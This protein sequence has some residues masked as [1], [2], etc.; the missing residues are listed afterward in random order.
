MDSYELTR[1]GE[2]R[3]VIEVA[4]RGERLLNHPMYNKGSAF[5]R[6]ERQTFGLEGLL[7]DVV[8]PMERQAQRIVGH[9]ARKAD[10]LEKYIGLS[11]LQDRNEHLFYRVLL[12]NLEEYL[13]IVYTPTVGKASQRYSHIFRR[14]R[15]IFIT[16]RHRGRIAEVLRNAPFADVRLIVATDNSA[17]LGL[18]DQGAGGM[19]IPIGKLAIYCAAAGIH[20]TQTLPVSLDVGTDRDELLADDLY[21]G[22]REKR[23]RGE[24][25]ATLV[26]EFVDAV[27]EVFPRALLQWEDFSKRN[28]FEVLERHRRRIPSFND[29]I[30]GTGATALAGV[31]VADRITGRSLADH[32]VVVLG[33]GAAGKGIAMQLRAALRESGVAESELLHR[34]AMLDSRGLICSRREDL[35]AYKR[36]LAWEGEYAAGLGLAIGA[37]LLAVVKAVRPTVLIGTSGVPRSFD[38]ATIRAVAE[39]AERPIVMPFSNPTD[40]SEATPEDVL[41]WTAGGA[42]VA[43]GSP[44]PPVEIEGRSVEIGQGNN[45]LVFPGVG[46]GVLV[47]EAREVSDGMF[48]A[49]AKA[50]AACVDES[51]LERNRLYPRIARL[52]E[53]TRR[54]AEAVVRQAREEGIGRQWSD[55]EV[56][57]AVAAAMWEPDYP[58]MV[59]AP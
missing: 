59:P 27:A 16:P 53:V 34:I 36:E 23:L 38:E 19:V 50:L 55:G 29:D 49:A 28:A 10:P 48:T 21:M 42:L 26:D 32:R 58:E 56:G 52:R 6:T 4:R 11:A 18:G 22:W 31:L 54:V 35:E 46:L 41:R 13:P 51:A 57:S 12:D 3:P 17:I 39:G 24:E 5:S 37:D 2:G 47:A 33:A 45:A 20:P 8:T 15:G 14:G 1:S 7:P 30:Q 40:Q 43:T 44:F 9:I 25:Y